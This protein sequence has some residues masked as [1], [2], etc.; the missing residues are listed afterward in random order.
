MQSRKDK[1]DALMNFYGYSKAEARA[2]LVDM[3]E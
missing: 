1:I 3:G 2:I